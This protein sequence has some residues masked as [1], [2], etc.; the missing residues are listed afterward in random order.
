MLYCRG[1]CIGI[2]SRNGAGFYNFTE[3]ESHLKVD[4]LWQPDN[5]FFSNSS[6]VS[7]CKHR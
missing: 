1:A 3:Q 2:V 4:F 6:S 7:A 5:L